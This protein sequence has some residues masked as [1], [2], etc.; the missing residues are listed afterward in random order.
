MYEYGSAF[1]SFLASFA[2][3]PAQRIVP[4]VASTLPVASIAD[5]GRGQGAW[6]HV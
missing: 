1:Y 4:L 5:F 6:L 3:R 2:V